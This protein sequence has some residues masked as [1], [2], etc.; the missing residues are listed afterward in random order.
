[1]GEVAVDAARLPIAG[2]AGIDDYDFVEIPG[3]PERGAESGGTAANY[4][5]IIWFV[6]ACRVAV[7]VRFLAPLGIRFLRA[8]CHEGVVLA[9]LDGLSPL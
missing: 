5:N 2:I 9:I 8:S 7:Q 6:R 4:R 1:M 3:E